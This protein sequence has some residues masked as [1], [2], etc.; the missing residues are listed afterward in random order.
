LIVSKNWSISTIQVNSYQK[1]RSTVDIDRR[2]GHTPKKNV[3]SEFAT[4][5]S[6]CQQI[7]TIDLDTPFCSPWPTSSAFH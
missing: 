6:Q 7:K 2:S 5:A 4:H 1:N 3:D